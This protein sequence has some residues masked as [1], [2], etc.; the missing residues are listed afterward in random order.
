[1]STVVNRYVAHTRYKAELGRACVDRILDCGYA[2]TVVK[3][4]GSSQIKCE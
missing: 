2:G 1:V 4:L 3:I